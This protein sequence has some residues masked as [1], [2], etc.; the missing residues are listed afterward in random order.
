MTKDSKKGTL[1]DILEGK[2]LPPLSTTST[3]HPSGVIKVKGRRCLRTRKAKHALGYTTRK[4]TR[5]NAD[6]HFNSSKVSRTFHKTE[7]K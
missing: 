6:K 4:R 7:V 2:G 3:S 5:K 1:D